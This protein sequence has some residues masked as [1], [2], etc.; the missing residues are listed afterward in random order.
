MPI[1]SRMI[2]YLLLAAIAAILLAPAAFPSN[3]QARPAAKF[4]LVWSAPKCYGKKKCRSFLPF[5]LI[6][7]KRGPAQRATICWLG[8]CQSTTDIKYCRKPWQ[9]PRCIGGRDMV[10]VTARYKNVGPYRC[11]SGT[12]LTVIYRGKTYTKNTKIFCY[13]A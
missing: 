10:K 4:A 8:N 1:S 12:K 7:D 2:K 5:F 11:G 9:K 3:S 13:R 6:R